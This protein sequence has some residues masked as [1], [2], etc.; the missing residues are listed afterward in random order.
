MP[1]NGSEPRESLSGELGDA[2][3]ESFDFDRLAARLGRPRGERDAFEDVRGER[4]SEVEISD[5][6]ARPTR[7]LH[8]LNI[9]GFGTDL[10][11][12]FNGQ[13][14]G[15]VLRVL[16]PSGTGLTIQSGKARGV[17]DGDLNWTRTC[18]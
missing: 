14:N 6:P 17:A 15:Y 2:I 9:G 7:T 11:N 4:P 8:Q 3:K 12:Q 1:G 13:C 18:A 16:E 5:Q 10:A